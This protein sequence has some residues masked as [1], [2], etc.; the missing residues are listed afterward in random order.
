MRITISRH[1]LAVTGL[2]MALTGCG[3]TAPKGSAGYADLQSP[4]V[5]DTDVTLSLSLG[6]SLLHFAASQADE[7]P[8]TRALLRDLD[9]VRV[10]IYEIDGDAARVSARL[11]AMHARLIEQQWESV[12]AVKEADERTYVMVKTDSLGSIAGLTVLDSSGTEVVIVNV[13]GNLRPESFSS[14]ME[15]LDIDVTAATDVVY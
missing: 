2:V 8:R 7:D 6:P 1:L 3:L 15:A 13:M 11:Q 9:G 4:G 12:I 10:R 5:F 14:A